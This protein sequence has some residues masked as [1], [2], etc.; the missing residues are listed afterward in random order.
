[1]EKQRKLKRNE[2]LSIRRKTISEAQITLLV[3]LAIF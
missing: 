3:D 2:S 1:M